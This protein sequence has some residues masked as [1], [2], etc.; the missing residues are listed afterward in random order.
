MAPRTSPVIPHSRAS[1]IWSLYGFTSPKDLV[2]EDLALAMG[3]LVF[4]DHLDGADARLVR[5]GAKGILRVKE[6]IP[7]RGRKRF[8]IAH[9]LGHWVLHEK[10]SQLLAC[11]SDDMVAQYKASPPEIEANY[12]ASALLMPEFL[13]RQRTRGNRPSIELV[14]SIAE[15]FDTSLTAAVLRYVELAKDYCAVVFSE[16]GKVRWWRASQDF[17]GVFWIDPG[18]PLS[19]YTVAGSIFRGESAP[20][21]PEEIDLDEWL[22]DGSKVESDSIIEQAIHLERYGQVISLLWLP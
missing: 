11:T 10:V 8:A 14:K 3:V 7:E 20:T 19:R 17:D 6:S 2:L 5:K 21:S 15:D 9:E 1:A 22:S 12:F 18:S 16:D 13:F 4:E